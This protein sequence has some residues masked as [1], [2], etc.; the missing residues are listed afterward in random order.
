MNKKIKFGIKLG[1]KVEVISGSDK[2][3][4]GNVFKLFKNTGKILVKGVNLKYKHVKPTKEGDV[5]E[6]KQIEAPIHHSNVRISK[7]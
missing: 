3:K 1:D 6:I 4:S 2:N 5:G 7:N